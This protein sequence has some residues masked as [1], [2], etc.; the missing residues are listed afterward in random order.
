MPAFCSPVQAGHCIVAVISAAR[1]YAVSVVAPYL[2]LLL[3]CFQQIP[4]IFHLGAV[5]TITGLYGSGQD[6]EVHKVCACP[7][8]LCFM[9]IGS[10][11]PPPKGNQSNRSRLAHN[12]QRFA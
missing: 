5:R 7:P 12:R 3:R 11:P 1:A 6:E 8:W 2:Q 4:M 10:P 9:K